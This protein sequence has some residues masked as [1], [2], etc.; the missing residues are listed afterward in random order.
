M[1]KSIFVVGMIILFLFN[2][3][4]AN[5]ETISL[6]NISINSQLPENFERDINVLLEYPDSTTGLFVLNVKNEFKLESPI[7]AGAAKVKQID[8]IG[9]VGQYEIISIPEELL[10]EKDK[11]TELKILVKE[12]PLKSLGDTTEKDFDSTLPS[13][14]ELDQGK[15]INVNEN[16]EERTPLDNA[17]ERLVRNFIC[18]A[19]AL[20]LVLGIY[21]I[22]KYK[23]DNK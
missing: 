8:I 5:A 1:K 2:G 6:G 7:Q 11:T 22:I 15:Q 14:D 20:I 18:T 23:Q 13:D 3:K 9:N 17:K 4:I 16:E 12:I 21:L 19:V 10:I